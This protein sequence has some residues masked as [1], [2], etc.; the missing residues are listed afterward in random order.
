MSSFFLGWRRKVGCIALVVALPFLV[1]L[2]RSRSLHDRVTF[3]TGA[4]SGESL[5]SAHYCLIWTSWSASQGFGPHAS[6]VEWERYPLTQDDPR[7]DEDEGGIDYRFRCLLFGAG[8]KS[9]GGMGNGTFT[10]GYLSYWCILV[11]LSLLSAGMILSKPRGPVL[12]NGSEAATPSKPRRKAG[13]V[14]LALALLLAAA[15][16][17]SFYFADRLGFSDEAHR[18][19][20]FYESL[21]GSIHWMSYNLPATDL[22]V[23]S[24]MDVQTDDDEAVADEDLVVP[25]YRGWQVI[26]QSEQ[27]S[28]FVSDDHPDSGFRWKARLLGFASGSIESIDGSKCVPGT[29]WTLPFWALVLPLT[30]LSTCLIFRKSRKPV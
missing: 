15:W 17:R 20:S 2:L 30:M 18:R 23:L 6:F 19:M 8:K 26:S 4:K 13:P 28:H 12:K 22:D 21:N 9:A 29:I 24:E 7:P 25:T 3:Y 1:G 14:T 16:A 10:Q 27:P 5:G 11:P